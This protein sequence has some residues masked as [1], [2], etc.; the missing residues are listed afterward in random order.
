[1]AVPTDP[2]FYTATDAMATRLGAKAEDLLWV[3][4]SETVYNP[5]LTGSARTISTLMHNVVDSGLL[6]QAE[7]DSLP[8]LTATQQLPFIERFFK[9][10]HDKYLGGRGF[11]DAFE[12]YLA[13]A[14]P[15]LLRGDGLYN[16]AT[17]MYGDP[18]NPA[19]TSIW[20]NNWPIDS[21]PVATNEAKARGIASPFPLSFGEQL[22]SEGKLKGW[23]TLGDLKSFMLRPDVAYFANQAIKNL[24][25]V[26]ATGAIAST[27]PTDQAYVLASSTDVAPSDVPYVPDTGSLTPSAPIDDRVAPPLPTLRPI[28]TPLELIVI[29]GVMYFALRWLRQ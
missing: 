4:A 11:K 13:N 6:T 18:N 5:A 19:H 25:S 27:S 12:A 29:A 24:K 20:R 28:L 21:Y 23:I 3:W 9:E 8:T 15:G 17:V 7:W 2:A 22:V 1:M 26:R 10:L 14:A 16:P